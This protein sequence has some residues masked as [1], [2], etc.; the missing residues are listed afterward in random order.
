METS[1]LFEQGFKDGYQY[2]LDNPFTEYPV[3]LLLTKHAKY[4][5][6]FSK[7]YHEAL[8]CENGF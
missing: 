6:G 2:Y 7:G 4:V 8:K 5:E 3:D 1:E